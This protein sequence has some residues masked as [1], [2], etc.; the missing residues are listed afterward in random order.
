VAEIAVKSEV[1]G[2]VGRI[3][4]AIGDPVIPDSEIIIVEAMKMELPVLAAASGVVTAILV[5]I[6][7]TVA[8]GQAVALVERRPAAA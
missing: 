6:G 5:H 1:A 2:V 3:V 7:D 4:V 8:E